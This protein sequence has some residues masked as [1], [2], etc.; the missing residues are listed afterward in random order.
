MRR[1]AA[2]AAAN[3]LLRA[4]LHRVRLGQLPKE[5]S[6]ASE[7]DG[8]QIQDLLHPKLTSEG[9]GPLAGRKIGCTTPV[10]QTYLN[11]D[12]PCAGGIAAATV[13]RGSTARV[14]AANYQRLG[15]ECEI[16]VWLGSH[17]LPENAPYNRESVAEAVAAV[18]PAIELVDDRY[19]DYGNFGVYSLIADDFFNAGCVLGRR[20]I[21]AWRKLD[22]AAVKGTMWINGSEIG[23]GSGADIMGH[24][25]EALA[26]I[27]NNRAARGRGLEANSFVLLGSVVQTQWLEAGDSVRI[28]LDGLGEVTLDV[29]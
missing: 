18:M 4:R 1:R 24:P 11:I 14:K 6:P 10:M 19:E 16:A 20:R 28:A 2:E 3:E 21:K 25:F 17:L 9:L 22:L 23:H 8:Y 26:W 27:A 15:V 7:D 13:Q 5:I 12:Q 29:D